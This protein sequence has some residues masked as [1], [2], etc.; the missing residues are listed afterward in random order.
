LN[1]AT[2][3]HPELTRKSD[4]DTNRDFLF[5]LGDL[6]SIKLDININP[7]T[8]PPPR[9][10]EIFDILLLPLTPPHPEKEILT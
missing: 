3:C 10:G 6:G 9:R 2:S 4:K 5:L 7:S 8:C 1:P